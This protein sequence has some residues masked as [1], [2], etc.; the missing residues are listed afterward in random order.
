M[1]HRNPHDAGHEDSAPALGLADRL[2]VTYAELS[3]LTGIGKS[4]LRRW[5]SELDMPVCRIRGSVLIVLA[6]WLAWVRSFCGQ[7]DP[8]LEA[9]TERILREIREED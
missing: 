1:K 7:L 6:D 8:D 5:A 9:A 2:T 4:T 3:T